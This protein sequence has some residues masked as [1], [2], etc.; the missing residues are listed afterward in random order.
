VLNKNTYPSEK[1]EKYRRFDD[2]T[3]YIFGKAF[4]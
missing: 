1:A 3:P 4:L 2:R